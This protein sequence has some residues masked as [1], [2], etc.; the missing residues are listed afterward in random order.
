MDLTRQER[1]TYKLEDIFLF[2]GRQQFIQ[3]PIYIYEILDYT[4]TLL[5]PKAPLNIYEVHTG[6]YSMGLGNL[7]PSKYT[8]ILFLKYKHKLELM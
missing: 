1:Q 3:S 6:I 7:L 4:K 5:F 8:C 2:L